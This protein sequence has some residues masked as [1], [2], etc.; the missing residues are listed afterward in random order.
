[1][2]LHSSISRERSTV[3]RQ[4]NEHIYKVLGA[5]IVY[6]CPWPFV[7]SRFHCKTKLSEAA[8]D[9]SSLASAGPMRFHNPIQEFN[10]KNASFSEFSGLPE[11][12]GGKQ[13]SSPAN[14]L[15]SI[16]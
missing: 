10:V 6:I 4:F 13:V 8:L 15:P 5:T 9:P 11:F 3:K 7:I 1:M 12:F 16:N 14:I 2:E